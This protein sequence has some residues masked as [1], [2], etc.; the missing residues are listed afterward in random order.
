MS[1]KTPDRIFYCP[2]HGRTTEDDW[3]K[4]ALS[5]ALYGALLGTG[6]DNCDQW[7]HSRPR[8]KA[9]RAGET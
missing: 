4:R 7:Y 8:F 3:R 5:S 9:K 2:I 1:Q 6:C